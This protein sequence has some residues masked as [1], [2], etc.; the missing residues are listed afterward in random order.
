MW[1]TMFLLS[2]HINCLQH[3]ILLTDGS[4]NFQDN[5]S[6]K[7][8]AIPRYSSGNSKKRMYTY[9]YPEKYHGIA[10][11]FP[12]N[13]AEPAQPDYKIQGSIVKMLSVSAVLNLMRLH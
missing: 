11:V 7:V 9:M 2:R 4:G 5:Y 3:L 13:F 10:R 1:I 6:D 12:S 8:R